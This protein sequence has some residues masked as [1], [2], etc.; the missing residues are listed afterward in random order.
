M[1]LEKIAIDY[2]KNVN[3]AK[4]FKKYFI[5][6]AANKVINVKGNSNEFLEHREY[7]HSDGLKNVNWKLF[8][9][10]GKLFSKVF[11]TEISKEVLVLLDTSKSMVAG[12]SIT[13]IEYSKYLVS[14][15]SYK[16]LSEGYKVTFLTFD[17]H[18]NYFISLSI[19]NFNKFDSF[20]GSVKCQGKTDFKS[21]IKSIPNFVKKNSSILLISD[22]IFISVDDISTLRKIFPKKDIVF[23]QVLSNVELSFTEDEFVEFVDPET[24]NK[25]LVLASKVKK[26]Y[27][28]KFSSFV[29]NVFYWSS[30]NRI[31]MLTF[32]T[33]IPYYVILKGI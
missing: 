7:Y 14:I 31:S 26:N 30:S 2:L 17:S 4:I 28:E 23:F 19:R 10:T 33:S 3:L 12:E 13:K 21:V 22:F 32:P 29:E 9:K 1:Y 20:L 6:E 11:S 18:I 16:L 25:K 5:S 24:Q 8:A 15:V 27:I